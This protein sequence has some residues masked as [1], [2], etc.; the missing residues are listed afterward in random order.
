M[1]S[2]SRKTVPCGLVETHVDSAV[3]RRLSPRTDCRTVVK[4]VIVPD[5]DSGGAP[6]VIRAQS[7]D[8]SDGGAS[9]VSKEPLPSRRVFLRFLL[10]THWDRYLEAVVV[11]ESVCEQVSFTKRLV[12]QYVYRVRFTGSEFPIDGDADPTSADAQEADRA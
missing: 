4:A 12:R 5:S 10:P 7:K 3:D 2:L 1:D 8:V 11:G 6:T 9:L